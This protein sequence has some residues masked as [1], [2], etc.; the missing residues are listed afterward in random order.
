M[1]RKIA[2]GLLVL[3]GVATY[4]QADED[5]CEGW[6]HKAYPVHM[7]ACSYPN[8]GSGYTRITNN[9]STAAAI[10]WTV[11]T[12]SGREI[13]NYSASLSAS[14]EIDF[15]SKNR[16]AALAADETATAS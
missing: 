14:Y 12:N 5:I 4:A 15:W 10:C 3:A 11:V 2:L 7:E 13:V 16:D 9:G 8:G 6:T 1:I